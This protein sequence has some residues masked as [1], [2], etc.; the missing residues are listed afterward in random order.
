MK[1]WE[2]LIR[3]I[4]IHIREDKYGNLFQSWLKP[5]RS[6]ML[7]ITVR[8]NCWDILSQIRKAF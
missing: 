2:T 4:E 3:I 5:T 6:Q 8:D 1:E 7:D